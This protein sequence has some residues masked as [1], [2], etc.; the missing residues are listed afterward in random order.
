ML[1]YL[2]SLGRSALQTFCTKG[3]KYNLVILYLIRQ[4]RKLAFQTFM[5][6]QDFNYSNGP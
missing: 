2:T 1:N 5:L 6:V 4:S 3:L